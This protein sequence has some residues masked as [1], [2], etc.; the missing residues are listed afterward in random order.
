MTR[1]GKIAQVVIA[2]LLLL[3]G[4]LMLAGWWIVHRA[5]P[6]LDG[7]VAVSGLKEG[8]IVDRDRWGR[9]WIRARSVDDLLMAQGYVTAQDRLWQ[10][11]LLRRAAAGDLSE[12][13]GP[14]TLK[15]DEEN[16]TL[17]MR[18]AAERAVADSN[19]A[20]RG[21]LEA[22]ARGVN[23]YIAERQQKLPVEF[24][25]LHYSPR[26]WTP[27]DTYL[28]SLYMWK[29][30]T[31]TWKSK[32]N[33][34]WI[35]EKVGPERTAQ[36][37]TPDS[38]LDHYIVGQAGAAALPKARASGAKAA[39]AAMLHPRGAQSPPFPPPVMNMAL[40]FLAQFDEESSEIIGS[41][42]FVVS[43]AHTATHKPMLANDTHLVLGAPCIWYLVHLSA[44][45]WNVEAS[46][47]RALR[48]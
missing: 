8:V 14:L 43:G 2:A 10:M 35:A 41:N 18:Q 7:Q 29:T 45:G 3:A 44:P 5:L 24:S 6:K 12:I 22:Y 46:H 34:A 11:D 20:I 38:P 17:G 27:A 42:N 39:T 31:S 25:L 13:I 33:R 4:L 9:P 36:M 32:L 15:F 48:W 1:G 16:R 26:P 37:F 40:D 19:P 30:L 47:C 28:V 21:L 23:R